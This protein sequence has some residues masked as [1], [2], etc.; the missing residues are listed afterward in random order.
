MKSWKGAENEMTWAEYIIGGYAV[1]NDTISA[2]FIEYVMLKAT[3]E[4]LT[5]LQR[6]KMTFVQMRRGNKND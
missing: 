5:D 2:D 3:N 6:M 4:E 1:L